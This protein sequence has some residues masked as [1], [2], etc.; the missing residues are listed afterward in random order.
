M[1]LWATA[2][3]TAGAPLHHL[4]LAF[5][6]DRPYSLYLCAAGGLNVASNLALIPMSGL[7]GAAVAT[8]AANVLLAGLLWRGVERRLP[9]LR[10]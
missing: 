9:S 6:D 4:F 1:L 7:I 8:I 2:V 10:R 5:G 3:A